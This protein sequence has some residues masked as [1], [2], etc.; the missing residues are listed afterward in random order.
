MKRFIAGED[1][2]QI[3]LLPDCLDDYITRSGLSALPAR[4]SAP[5]EEADLI[6]AATTSVSHGPLSVPD[7]ERGRRVHSGVL[8]YPRVSQAEGC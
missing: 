3:T 6:A 8:G 1:R 2:Q 7:A 5:N 4:M